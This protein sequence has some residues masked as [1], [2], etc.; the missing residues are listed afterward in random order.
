MADMHILFTRLNW[1]EE[2]DAPRFAGIVIETDTSETGYFPAL[3]HRVSEDVEFQDRDAHASP[4]PLIFKC[5]GGG[6]L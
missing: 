5:D 4:G 6:I 3:W 1:K 2:E